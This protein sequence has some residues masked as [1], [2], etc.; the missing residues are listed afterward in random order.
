MQEKLCHQSEL[1]LVSSQLAQ[2]YLHSALSPLQI[3]LF[4][5]D[6]RMRAGH[7]FPPTAPTHEQCSTIE[8]LSD[9]RKQSRRQQIVPRRSLLRSFILRSGAPDCLFMANFH[10]GVPSSILRVFNLYPGGVYTFV[11]AKSSPHRIDGTS[12]SSFPQ[13]SQATNII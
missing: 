5:H 13:R 7:R 8:F 4:I 10:I 1:P 3:S 6:K 12:S 2:S 9:L 11:Q